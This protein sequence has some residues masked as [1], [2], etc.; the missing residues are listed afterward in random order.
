MGCAKM[1]KEW[2]RTKDDM[3]REAIESSKYYEF[4]NVACDLRSDNEPYLQQV[5][6]LLAREVVKHRPDLLNPA[7]NDVVYVVCNGASN[8]SLPTSD[9]TTL[10]ESEKPF[11]DAFIGSYSLSKRKLLRKLYKGNGIQWVPFGRV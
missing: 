5:A 6:L 4:E 3:L 1:A 11:D 10:M 2:K 8:Y 7:D 9:L